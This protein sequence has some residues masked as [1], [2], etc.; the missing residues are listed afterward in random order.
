M[1]KTLF[2]NDISV[3]VTG[4]VITCIFYLFFLLLHDVFFDLDSKSTIGFRRSYV[5]FELG[6]VEITR[7]NLSNCK[8]KYEKSIYWL[9]CSLETRGYFNK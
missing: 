3:K 7:K 2:T 9:F 8:K 4:S 6:R 1:L 5:I